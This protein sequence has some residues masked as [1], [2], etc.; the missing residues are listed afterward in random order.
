[1]LKVEVKY[2]DKECTTDYELMQM[3]IPL[4]EGCGTLSPQWFV[5]C[6]VIEEANK[7]VSAFDH[8]H[9]MTDKG[10]VITSDD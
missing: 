8:L 2:S 4:G 7:N 6:D 1:M 5:R 3:D 10:I 9:V